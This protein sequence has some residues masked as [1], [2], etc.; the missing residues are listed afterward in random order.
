MS[1][2]HQEFGCPRC[3]GPD[4]A[5]VWEAHRA[6]RRIAD[7]VE[8]SH[9]SLRLLACPACGQSFLKVFTELI[10]WQGGDDSQ[11]W[12]L[13][14]LTPEEC[15]QL[16]A[17]GEQVDPAWLTDWGASSASGAGRLLKESPSVTA[18]PTSAPSAR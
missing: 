17:A 1:T 8:E 7:L 6:D 10:D 13:L 18:A 15:D 5:S 9:F 16:L 14:P 3:S 11:C 12:C 4:A 2:P